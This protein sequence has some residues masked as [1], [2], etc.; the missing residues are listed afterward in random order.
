MA[1]YDGFRSL[2]CDAEQPSFRSALDHSASQPET[3]PVKTRLEVRLYRNREAL[4]LEG[5]Q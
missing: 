3:Q 2:H 4:V 5:M 1:I